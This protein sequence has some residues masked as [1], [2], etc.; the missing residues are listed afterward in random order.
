VRIAKTYPL[1]EA[2]QAHR[3]MEARAPGKL[4]LIP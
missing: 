1:A 2:V 3:N 4:L